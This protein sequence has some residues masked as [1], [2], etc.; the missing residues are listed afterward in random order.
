L[1]SCSLHPHFPH[2]VILPWLP[3]RSALYMHLLIEKSKPPDLI[4]PTRIIVISFVPE[5]QKPDIA[6]QRN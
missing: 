6:Q 1:V 5:R 4:Y 3:K 2:H